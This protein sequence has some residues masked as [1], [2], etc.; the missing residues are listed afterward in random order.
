MARLLAVDALFFL[1]PFAAYAI[2][3][4]FARRPVG[5]GTS[6]PLR[7]VGVLSMV[8]AGLVLAGLIALVSFGGSP[9][10]GEYHPA[11]LQNGRVV[12]GTVR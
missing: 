10:G 9:P 3:L 8:G 11:S 7:T 4:A 1:L 6:W 5:V 12:P 2:W